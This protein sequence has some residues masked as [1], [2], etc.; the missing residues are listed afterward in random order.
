MT[1]WGYDNNDRGNNWGRDGKNV[2]KSRGRENNNNHDYEDDDNEYDYQ[3]DSY[4]MRD[5]DDKYRK[6]MYN[7]YDGMSYNTE[8]ICMMMMMVWAIIT[9]SLIRQSFDGRN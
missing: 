3:H 1:Q 9:T 5:K 2:N 4:R 6:N 7:D 8:R